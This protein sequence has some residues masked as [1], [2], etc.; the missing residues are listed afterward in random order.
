RTAKALAAWFGDLDL[1]RHLPWPLFKRVPDNGGEVA[2]S[3]GHFLEQAGNQQAIDDLLAAGVRIR[4][5]HPPSAKLRDGLDL[6]ALLVEAEI[7]TITRLRAEALVAALP[8]AAAIVDAEPAH[9]LAAGL[10]EASA[11]SLQSWLEQPGHPQLLLDG[12]A[13]IARLLTLAPER[14]ASAAGPLDGQAVVLTGTLSSMSRD[15]AGARLEA[16]GAK[17]AGS[18]S[19]KT[20][21]VV[22]GENAGSKLAKAQELGIEIWDEAQLLAFLDR[23][24]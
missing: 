18:V 24:A 11:R 2:R 23:H 8:D 14:D 5:P 12:E 7:P 6:A 9:L 20:H 22:A 13:A 1:I 3:L 16:L 10:P 15:E 19:K 17:V 21:L 4:D